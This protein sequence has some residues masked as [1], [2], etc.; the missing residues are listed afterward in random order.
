MRMQLTVFLYEMWKEE[1]GKETPLTVSWG[2]VHNSLE[3]ILDFSE[4]GKVIVSHMSD[5]ICKEY[6]AQCP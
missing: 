5:Y 3:M 1:F 2:K 4:S 6:A